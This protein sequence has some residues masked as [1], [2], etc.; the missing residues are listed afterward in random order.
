MDT[1]ALTVFNSIFSSGSAFV[2]RCAND[3]NFTMEFMAGQVEKLCGCAKSDILG[4]AKV[5]YVGLT[6]KDDI[7]RV[8]AD[9][10][11]AIEAK[12]NWDVAY[13]LSRPDGTE[14]WVRERGNA[15]YDDS[16][17]MVYLEGLVVDASAEVTLRKELQTTLNRTEEA[18]AEII[19]LAENILRSVQKLSILAINAGIEAARAGKAGL[20]FAYLAREIKA[21][22]DENN[23][24][25]SRITDT[26]AERK[27]DE[28]REA[29]ESRRA[30]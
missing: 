21:L 16:G 5:S 14:A 13:R 23:Q 10:D 2:Y 15:V 4:N 19:D 8:F 12:E 28:A 18:N 26:M 25:A 29:A 7:D 9:V 24:W 20:G 17:E 30:G 3:E 6:H 1:Q 11:A 22:A 27:R